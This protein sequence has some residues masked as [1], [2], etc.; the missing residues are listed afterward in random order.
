M[1]KTDKRVDRYIDNAAEFAQPILHH[2]RALVHEFCPDVEE[3]IKWSFPNFEY[4][5]SLL[6]SMAAFKKHC[7]FS[8]WKA[9]LMQ[10]PEGLFTITPAQA[11]GHFGKLSSVDQIPSKKVLRS[12]FLDAMKL[13]EDGVTV[14]KQAKK[15]T[16]KDVPMPN[17]FHD[18]LHNNPKALMSFEAFSPS[19]R[20][21]YLRWITEAKQEATRQRRMRQAIEQLAEGKTRD[22]KYQTK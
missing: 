15:S 16:P 17:D 14:P 20:R 10:D 4:R 1:A 13:N 8:F 19:H 5:G 22:W 2:I 12:Y 11:M 18:M 21:E 6:C 9:S 3:T 7:A